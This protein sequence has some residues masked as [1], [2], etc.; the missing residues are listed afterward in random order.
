[1]GLLDGH[2]VRWALRVDKAR[3]ENLDKFFVFFLT[4]KV[5]LSQKH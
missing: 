3:A 2:G 5:I 1:M 4:V